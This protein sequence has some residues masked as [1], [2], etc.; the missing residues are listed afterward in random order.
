M[1]GPLFVCSPV[2]IGHVF[3]NGPASIVIVA[4]L[5]VASYSRKSSTRKPAFSGTHYQIQVCS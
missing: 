2:D 4:D 5:V 1:H 3:L